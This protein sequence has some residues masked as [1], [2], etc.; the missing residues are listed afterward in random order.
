MSQTVTVTLSRLCSWMQTWR[1]VLKEK[2]AVNFAG[3]SMHKNNYMGKVHEARAF[4]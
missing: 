4:F 1:T 2:K 3:H